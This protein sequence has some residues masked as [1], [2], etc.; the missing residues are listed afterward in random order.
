MPRL[1]SALVTLA[2]ATA[3]LAMAAST[4]ENC[5]SGGLWGASCEATN[6][7]S[8]VDIG[9]SLTPPSTP[10][11]SDDSSEY[12][13]PT[14]QTPTRPSMPE[15]D[16]PPLCRGNYEV[17]LPPEVTI[18]DLASFRPAA[19]TAGG[20][21]AGFGV[22][23]L[24]TNLVA[25]AS[26]Q[27]LAGSLLGWEVRVRFV[28]S[29]FVFDNG[30]GTTTRSRSGGAS[31]AALG[32]T[33]FSPT[34]T[35]HVYRERGVYTTSAT[36]QYSASVDFGSGTWR[37]VAGVVTARSAGYDIRVV[38][39]STALVDRTCREDPSGPGC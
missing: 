33:Q 16:L 31:W 5:G 2:I 15:C 39:A 25:E 12:G 10:G 22:V 19:P 13:P 26:E 18:E 30:D 20:E 21:P 27:I 23:N 37:P 34:A 38:E 24:P 3:S 7:G 32:Q 9:A 36:V 14:A 4:T 11:G 35:S 8:Q 28:P 17:G 1:A 29:G 6:T